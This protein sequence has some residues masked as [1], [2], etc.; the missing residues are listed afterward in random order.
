MTEP[1]S[2]VARD[3]EFR[4]RAYRGDRC[5][6]F[7]M[8][9]PASACDGLAGFA[10]ARAVDGR[11]FAYVKNRLGFDPSKGAYA[12]KDPLAQLADEMPSNEAPF[13]TFRWVDFP[14][15]VAPALTYPNDVKSHERE[16]FAS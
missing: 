10:I 9:L 4:V 5:A 16:L 1:L 12:T 2:I 11:T 8:D 14:P 3:R 13:Q 15:D 6:M 7:A